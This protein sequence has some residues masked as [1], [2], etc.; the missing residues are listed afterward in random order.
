[1]EVILKAVKQESAII[2]T[3]E[4]ENF[5][6][7]LSKQ[8]KAAQDELN[9]LQSTKTV[10]VLLQKLD[11]E[12]EVK[13]REIEKQREMIKNSIANCSTDEERQRLMRQYEQYEAVVRDQLINQQEIQSS[14]LKDAI[15]ARN[16]RR[17]KLMAEISDEK[18]TKI[19]KEFREM[20]NN[21]VNGLTNTEKSKILA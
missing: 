19:F 14:K 13:R 21:K 3:E 20:T 2:A 18:Q 5:D 9:N 12:N 17:K 7:E 16:N 15:Q 6:V 8:A 11:A 1:M 4:A 10:D